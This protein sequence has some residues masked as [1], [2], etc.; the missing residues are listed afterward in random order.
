MRT[1]ATALLAFL[2]TVGLLPTGAWAEHKTA[3]GSL[4]LTG[5]PTLV[6]SPPTL[7]G[8][9]VI[10]NPGLEKTITVQIPPYTF[11]VAVNTNTDDKENDNNL[12]TLVVLTNVSAGSETVVFTLRDPS[13]T[14]ITLTP[15]TFVVAANNTLAVSVAS[16]LP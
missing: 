16:L 10:A 12:D 14:P 15:N 3:F 1:K 4:T 9:A 2:L 11:P 6:T 8:F 13:G 7:V 5:S